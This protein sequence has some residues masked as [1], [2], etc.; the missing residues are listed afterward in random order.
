MSGYPSYESGDK[1]HLKPLGKVIEVKEVFVESG[2][3][4]VKVEEYD[5]SSAS[6]EDISV[7]TRTITNSIMCGYISDEENN[8]L[9]S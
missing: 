9:P 2:Q 1:F 6:G 3:T 5:Y 7:D 8:R 4:K